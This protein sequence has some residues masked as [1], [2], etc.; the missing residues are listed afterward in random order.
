MIFPTLFLLI[1]I[2]FLGADKLIGP[3]KDKINEHEQVDSYQQDNIFQLVDDNYISKDNF[4][5]VPAFSWMK[6]IK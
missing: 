6:K 4:F 1:Q 3:E 5:T 2:G